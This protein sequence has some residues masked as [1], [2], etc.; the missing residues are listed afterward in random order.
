ME[1]GEWRM[2]NEGVSRALNKAA[3][4]MQNPMHENRV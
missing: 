3:G 2:R 1:N 4:S